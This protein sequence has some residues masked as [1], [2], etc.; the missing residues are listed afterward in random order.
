[1]LIRIDLPNDET[2]TLLRNC[3]AAMQALVGT[4]KVEIDPK[5]FNAG[6]IIK[7]YGSMACKGVND[8]KRPWRMSRLTIA[9]L[10]ITPAP[11][12]LLE[13]L[14]ALAPKSNSKRAV[15]ES[16][17][18]GPWTEANTQAYLDDGTNWECERRDPRNP[19][20]EIAMWIGKCIVD[21]NHG[22]A[23]LI[24]HT[25]GWWS[26]GCFHAGCNGTNHRAFMTYW[27]KEKGP[28]KYPANHRKENAESVLALLSVLEAEADDGQPGGVS[29]KNEIPLYNLTDAGN[30]ER[31]VWCHGTRLKHATERGWFMWDN[32]RWRPDAKKQVKVLSL[33]TVRKIHEEIERACEGL[34]PNNED[35]AKEIEATQSRYLA[36]QHTSENSGRL[37]AMGELAESFL[38]AKMDE[39]D[40]DLMLFHEKQA[41]FAAFLQKQ[42]D[43]GIPNDLA[44]LAPS[45]FVSAVEAAEGK[46]LDES[47]IKW[48]T[49]GDTVTARFL[50]KEFFQFQPQFKI[51]LGTNHKPQIIGT[52]EGIWRRI[53]LIPFE[54]Y[55]PDA[56]GHVWNTFDTGGVCPACLH[57]WT[58]TQCL[59]CKRWSPRSE[60]YAQ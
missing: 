25:D 10:V 18:K 12:E 7:A 19:E 52:D 27:E 6:R 22:D 59:S 4:G 37:S 9:P 14:A 33:D 3:I 46:R 48:I 51:W 21:G 35:E 42:R 30:M 26:W 8:E 54:V 36:W 45:R 20:K 29:E 50:H 17:A 49:G 58:E 43:E 15:E 56:G 39:F 13:K 47:K 41:N 44:A 11:K 34:D 28:Y 31:L 2:K 16:P 55:I 24:L 5:M 38:P 23:A 53:K 1:V 40:R 32:K 60:W 57:Q